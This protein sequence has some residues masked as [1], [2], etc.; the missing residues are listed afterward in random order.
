VLLVGLHSVLLGIA[1]LAAPRALSEHFG[2]ATGGS[3]FFPSQSG[4]FLLVL[5]VCYL[6]A[7]RDGSLLVVLVLSKTAAVLFL[8]VHVVLLDGPPILWAVAGGDAAMLAAT[9]GAM[10]LA[11][12][13][14]GA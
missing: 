11:R 1:F 5:G 2:L 8:L 6:L 3:A 9:L 12:P 7:L 4:V 10:A 13:R 14:V